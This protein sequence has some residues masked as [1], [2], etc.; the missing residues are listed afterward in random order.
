MQQIRLHPN[1]VNIPIFAL[2]A[3]AMTSDRDR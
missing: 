3:L 1:L 2:T